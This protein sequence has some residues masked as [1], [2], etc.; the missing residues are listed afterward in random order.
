M[1]GV[2]I[3]ELLHATGAWKWPR[4]ATLATTLVAFKLSFPRHRERG[5]QSLVVDD[6]GLANL[7]QAIKDGIGQFAPF[8]SDLRPPVR[9]A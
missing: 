4:R 1:V 9:T 8:V 6:V 2:I 3:D 5:C 7:T